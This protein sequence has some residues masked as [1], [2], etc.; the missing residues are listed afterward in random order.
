MCVCV[1]VCVCMCACVGGRACIY[2]AHCCLPLKSFAPSLAHAS[3]FLK[4]LVLCPTTAYENIVAC[5]I[6]Y[7]WRGKVETVCEGSDLYLKVEP[8]RKRLTVDARR[9]GS[10]FTD[11][12][13]S[14]HVAC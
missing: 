8:L 3:S 1:C 13:E 2:P 5:D 11:L 4:Q 9:T 14:T 6:Q 7:E 10:V 12:R